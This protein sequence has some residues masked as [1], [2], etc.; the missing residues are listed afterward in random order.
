MKPSNTPRP[1][2]A[3]G[4]LG[5]FVNHAENLPYDAHTIAAAL[6]PR[7]LVIDQGSS[8]PYTNSKATAIVVHP[9][10]KALYDWL[11]SGDQMAV[12]PVGAYANDLPVGSENPE[13]I[14]LYSASMLLVDAHL[15]RA[16]A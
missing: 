13:G 2:R 15:L 5:T 1:A 11:G 9:A 7:A 10:A 4:T 16:V 14:R 3:G 8:D 6:A 12:A